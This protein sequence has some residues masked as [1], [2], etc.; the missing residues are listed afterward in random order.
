MLFVT[1]DTTTYVSR[2]AACPFTVQ[3]CFAL[4]EPGLLTNEKRL[5]YFVVVFL[6]MPTLLSGTNKALWR[7]FLVVNLCWI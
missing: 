3:S 7:L 6:F 5:S 1:K 4:L 2:L